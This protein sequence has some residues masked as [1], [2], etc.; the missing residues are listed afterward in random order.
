MKTSPA[1][2]AAALIAA[3]PKRP[4]RATVTF[5]VPVTAFNSDDWYEYN[6]ATLQ[7]LATHS[8]TA[9]RS[10][11]VPALGSRGGVIVRGSRARHLALHTV[12]T[13]EVK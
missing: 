9:Y 1:Q 4:A 5:K 10:W 11:S 6:P 7:V 2:R 12:Q 8:P 13:R 3:L